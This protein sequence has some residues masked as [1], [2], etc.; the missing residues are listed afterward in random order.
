MSLVPTFDD[1]A[2]WVSITNTTQPVEDQ[3]T[4]CIDAAVE[5]ILSR[6]RAD[7]VTGTSNDEVPQCVRTAMLLY[8]GR[9]YK[10][11]QSPEGIAGFGDLGV[12]RIMAL[13]YDV[14]SLISRYVRM[15]G[16]A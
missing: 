9:L 2:D 15:D 3:L 11:K 8:G 14:E 16:F 7:V 12:V 1:L 5:E 13:D 6:C 10:R 4:E